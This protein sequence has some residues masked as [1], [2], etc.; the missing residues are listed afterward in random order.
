MTKPHSNIRLLRTGTGMTRECLAARLGISVAWL[1]QIE[2]YPDAFMT[3]AMA[4]RLAAALG[5][6]PD[7]LLGARG[8]PRPS[9]RRVL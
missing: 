5:V 2:R 6:R 4:R 7:D 9:G 1:A 3:T 8:A